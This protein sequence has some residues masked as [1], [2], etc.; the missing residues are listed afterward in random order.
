MKSA[1]TVPGMHDV[2]PERHD[3]FTF[4]KKVVRYHARRTGLRRVSLPGIVSMEALSHSL[5]EGSE[6]FRKGL[7]EVKGKKFALRPEMTTLSALTYISH[8]QHE[9]HPPIEWYYID[10]VWRKTEDREQTHEYGFELLGEGDPALDAQLI[11]MNMNI[12]K[13]LG[14]DTVQVRINT[15]GSREAQEQYA[16][17]LRNFFAGKERALS[18]DDKEKLEINPLRILA[19]EEEDTK[20]LLDLAP[21]ME[22]VLDKDSKE[23]YAKVKEY[24]DLLEIKYVEDPTLIPDADMYVGTVF[25]F[26]IDREVPEA[27]FVMPEKK[28]E[29]EDEK[30]HKKKIAAHLMEEEEE[31]VIPM[32]VRTFRLGG[33]GRYDDLVQKLSGS[34]DC[35]APGVGSSIIMEEVADSMENIHLKVPSKDKIDVFIVQLGD[36][37]KKVAIKLASDLRLHGIKTMGAL[38]KASIRSQLDSASRF[39][40]K[41]ALVIGQ[42]EV[43]EKK[44]IIRDM[45][46]GTQ[47]IIPFEGIVDRMVELLGVKA[48]DPKDYKTMIEE[49]SEIE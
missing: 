3:Y 7:F 31:I 32:E 35:T 47:E 43:R 17:D 21:K 2:L 42:M 23:H 44:I 6:I 25:A 10:Q 37:A 1:Y 11:E 41:Y 48:L 46:K 18:E 27:G 28:E 9:K 19:S 30:R 49:A 24:L 15:I 22:S 5:G 20:I 29:T 26:E 14:L 4:I 13:D 8:D 16:E 38:G 39:E 34:D 36:D 45:S 12:F 33:G 40:T